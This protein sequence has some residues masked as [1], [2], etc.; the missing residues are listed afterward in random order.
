MLPF[1]LLLPLEGDEQEQR[2][3]IEHNF[4]QRGALADIGHRWAQIAALCFLITLWAEQK[5]ST[6]WLVIGSLGFAL[7]LLLA[8][9]LAATWWGVGA[10][11]EK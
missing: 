2:R 11:R 6:L 7:T 8:C 4:K 10:L 5:N 3:I 9:A 1:S